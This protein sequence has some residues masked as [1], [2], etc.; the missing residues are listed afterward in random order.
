M[1]IKNAIGSIFNGKKTSNGPSG[2]VSNINIYWKG[3]LHSIPGFEIDGDTHDVI[4]PFTNHGAGLSFLKDQNKKE[5]IDSITVSDPFKIDLIAPEL[6]MAVNTGEKVDIH[7][8]IKNPDYNYSGPLTIKFGSASNAEIHLELQKVVLNAKGKSIKVSE[9]GEV[10]RIGKGDIFESSVQMLRAFKKGD[11]ITSVS[12]NKPFLFV[13]SEPELPFSIESDSSFIVIFYIK[14]PDFDYAG[15]L[16]L[17][18]M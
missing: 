3:A 11:A 5:I 9:S 16:E 12:V 1:S 10:K 15:S 14:A 17:N 6:P 2:S 18:I 7:I 13:R 4:I 8:K